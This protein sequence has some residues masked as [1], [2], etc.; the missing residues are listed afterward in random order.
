[1]SSEAKVELGA[2][3]IFARE[4]VF[5]RSILAEMGHKQPKTPAHTDNST[6]EGV[7]NN[8]IQPK[9]TKSMDMRFHWIR[10]RAC[11]GQLSVP[12]LQ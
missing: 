12:G 7:I 2:L 1:M 6:A 11:Q 5:I 3:Y 8:K 4:A 9:T 10:D